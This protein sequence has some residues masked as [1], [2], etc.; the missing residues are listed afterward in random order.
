MKF[1]AFADL[2]AHN[3]SQF[4]SILS[5]GTNTRLADCLDIF[6]QIREYG[7]KKGIKKALFLGDLFNTRTKVA[8]DV[9]YKV[10]DELAVMKSEGFELFLIVGNHDQFLKSGAIHSIRPLS[11]VA[12][13]IDKPICLK[14]LD[15]Y[16]IPYIEN[17][18]ARRGAI[19]AGRKA[20]AGIL[21]IHSPVDGALVG[22]TD[23]ALQDGL[24][25]AD[26]KGNAFKM[27]LLGHYHKS[28]KLAENVHFL[29]SP[30][31]LNL[32]ERNDGQKGF[33]VVDTE[34]YSMKMIPTQYPRFIE[35]EDEWTEEQVRNNF[36]RLVLKNS[37]EKDDLK[38]KQEIL[39][40]GGKA[41]VIERLQQEE[42]QQRLDIK[43]GMSFSEMLVGFVDNYETNLEKKKLIKTGKAFIKVEEGGE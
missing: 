20:G 19:M 4:S 27:I 2:H 23:V 32:G 24:K 12:T 18:E 10:F 3:Y 40:A 26:L 21:A 38:I 33:W 34:D 9:Y 17:L 43:P 13:V 8:I 6:R 25:L 11:S 31:E 16:A 35:L 41:V 7:E 22:P 5:D 1:L 15:V 39:A 36:V 37:K 14:E 42:V 30:L 28:Q 29:G